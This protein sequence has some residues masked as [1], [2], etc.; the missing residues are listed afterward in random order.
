MKFDTK[1]MLLLAGLYLLWKHHQEQGGAAAPAAA[2][3]P[4][5]K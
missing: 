4:A 3:A 5:T 2:P 1:T